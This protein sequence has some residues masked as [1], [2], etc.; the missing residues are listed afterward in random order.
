ML[1][2]RIGHQSLK[3]VTNTNCLQHPSPTSMLPDGYYIILFDSGLRIIFWLLFVTY[4]LQILYLKKVDG[5]NLS[6]KIP[7]SEIFIGKIPA[8]Y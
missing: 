2:L 3:L 7:S 5:K 6:P 4:K 1:I 8:K